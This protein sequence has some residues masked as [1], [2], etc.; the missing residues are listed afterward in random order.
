VGKK[1]KKKEV[2]SPLK[3]ERGRWGGEK[4]KQRNSQK[5]GGLFPLLKER[6]GNNKG[7]GKESLRFKW[8]FYRRGG[9]RDPTRKKKKKGIIIIKKETY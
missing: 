5:K 3:K 9:E 7:E 6:N 1:K 8:L 4:N 2:F